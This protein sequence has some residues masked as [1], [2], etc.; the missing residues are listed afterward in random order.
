M[1]DLGDEA[2]DGAHGV[3]LSLE[4]CLREMRPDEPPPPGHNGTQLAP[5]SSPPIS[6]S[7][8]PRLPMRR[9]GA[10]Q[11]NSAGYRPLRLWPA[12][13]LELDVVR[14]AEHEHTAEAKASVIG[15]CSTP[16]SSNRSFHPSSAAPKL[17]TW[18]PPWSRPINVSLRGF[19]LVGVVGIRADD[20]LRVDQHLGLVV[21][22][23]DLHLVAWVSPSTSV[24]QGSLTSSSLTVSAMWLT[25]VMSGMVRT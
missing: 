15:E 18:N 6:I 1:M 14:V 3:T 9:P 7:D 8:A 2:V 24:Y 4:E 12:E 21:G 19:P 20:E 5:S 25:P 10:I 23:L 22:L 16:S 17:S 13:H 11:D